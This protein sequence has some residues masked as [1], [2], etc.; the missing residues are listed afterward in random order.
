MKIKNFNKEYD[1][2]EIIFED[3]FII[4]VNKKNGLL[5]HCNQTTNSTS[6]VSLLKKYNIK[7]YEAEDSLRDGIVHRLDKDT[8]GLMVLAKNLFSYKNL[9]SQFH[10]RKVIKVYKAYC[11]GVPMPIAGTI[12]KP[13][14]NYLNRKKTSIEGRH[15][16]TNYKVTKNFKNYFSEIEC[17]ILT[18]RTHQIRV[19]MQSINCPLI[20]DQLYARNRNISQS[21][22][23]N[24]RSFLEVFRRQALHAQHLSF[25]HPKSKKMKSFFI[26]MPCDMLDLRDELVA[27]FNLNC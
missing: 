25:I 23:S 19:H 17:K 16:I 22:S 7:L 20:G 5:S 24:I 13:I 8:S 3:D 14:S 10:D 26:E 12:D 1:L 2:I 21:F 6:V 11:W 27:E 4:V 15:A 18:G 9:I